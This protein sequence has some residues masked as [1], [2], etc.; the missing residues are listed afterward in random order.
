MVLLTLLLISLRFLFSIF[1]FSK[2]LL[3]VGVSFW[4]QLGDCTSS[5]WTCIFSFFCKHLQKLASVLLAAAVLSCRY[6]L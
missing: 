1:S 4:L 2:F 6:L 5:G 3:H